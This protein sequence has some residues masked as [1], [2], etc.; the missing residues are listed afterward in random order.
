[1]NTLPKSTFNETPPAKKMHWSFIVLIIG[2]ALLASVQFVLAVPKWV[3]I[4]G[5]AFGGLGTYL[6]V[7]VLLGFLFQK[8]IARL[9][10]VFIW[11]GYLFLT[12]LLV[13]CYILLS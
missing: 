11:F 5:L 4:A 13:Y 7:D 12:A 8:L 1:M 9:P 10:F 2:G 6:I 3:S